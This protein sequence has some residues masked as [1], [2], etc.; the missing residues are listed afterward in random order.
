[1]ALATRTTRV[2]TKEVVSIGSKGLSTSSLGYSGR[3]WPENIAELDAAH[4]SRTGLSR[5]RETSGHE[6][7]V[8]QASR[9]FGAGFLTGQQQEDGMETTSAVD[10]QNINDIRT[11]VYEI[12]NV[13]INMQ[14]N[15]P[16]PFSAD[17]EELS[18]GIPVGLSDAGM[19]L[20][21]RSNM[22]YR[23]EVREHPEAK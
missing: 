22:D 5:N 13:N 2:L 3:I 18:P 6:V 20:E 9:M 15:V 23:L 4:N 14:T 8:S 21:A 7:S 19:N 12:F 11:K 17:C 16:E 1:L 10:D